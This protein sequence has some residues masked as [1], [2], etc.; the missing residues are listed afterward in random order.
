M[1]DMK[2]KPTEMMSGEK[3]RIENENAER[4]SFQDIK[5]IEGMTYEKAAECENR[6]W[7]KAE[8]GSK[9]KN[10]FE[11]TENKTKPYS[12]LTKAQRNEIKKETK[13]S[14][15]VI[16]YIKDMKQYQIY[17]EA[18]L[19]EVDINGRKCLV[20][21]DLDLDYRSPKTIDDAHPEGISNREL[22]KEGNAPYDAKTGEKIELHHMGQAFDSPLAELCENS[23]HGD[24]NDPILH[25]KG[26]ESWRRN[27]ELKKKYNNEQRPMHW[28]ERS[29]A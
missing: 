5:P 16:S 26:V 27:P 19:I 24:G 21:K 25:D 15:V 11:T 6:H 22:M 13:W 2:N 1:F 8:I 17:K 20:K 28:V 10:G 18:G 4:H 12:E 3:K 29:R 23:E 14:D 9:Q 7:N